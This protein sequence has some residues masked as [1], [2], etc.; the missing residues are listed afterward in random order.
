[1]NNRD[2]LLMLLAPEQWAVEARKRAFD[3]AG[4]PEAEFF[5]TEAR[6]YLALSQRIEQ[7]ELG[8]KK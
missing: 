7:L 2:A 4:M 6:R 1:M 5:L 3:Y 8:L